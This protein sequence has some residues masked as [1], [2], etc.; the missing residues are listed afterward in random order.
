[1]CQGSM[2]SRS[3]Q[4]PCEA[5]FPSHPTEEETEALRGQVNQVPGGG[6][7]F[8]PG[9]MGSQ[10]QTLPGTQH[11][12]GLLLL[13]SCR[14]TDLGILRNASD[15]HYMLFLLLHVESIRNPGGLCGVWDSGP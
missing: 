13:A 11:C 5:R 12:P 15:P 2:S 9:S 3:S 14:I 4:H 8:K 6:G 10:I 7:G 1:M